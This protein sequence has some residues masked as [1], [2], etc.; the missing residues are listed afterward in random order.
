[1]IYFRFLSTLF[2]MLF[3][4]FT[5]YSFEYSNPQ[6]VTFDSSSKVMGA[7]VPT[8]FMLYSFDADIIAGWNTPL[9]KHEKKYIPEKYQKLDVLGGWYGNG[10]YP[11]K[12]VLL[13]KQIDAAFAIGT[14]NVMTKEMGKFMST[15]NI[16]FISINGNEIDD[17][18][19]IYEIL[20]QLF[21]N[22]KRSSEINE[23][24]KKSIENTKSITDK[25]KNKKKVY[26]ALGD[27]GL[28]TSCVKSILIAGGEYVHKCKQFRE[29][30]SLEQLLRY[31]PDMIIIGKK[32]AYEHIMKD[33]KWAK[34]KAVKNHNILFVPEEPF[35]WVEKKTVMEYFVIQ[36]LAAKMYPEYS[37]L[38]L[39]SELVKHL[40]IFFHYDLS[41]DMAE[42]LINY[43][44]YYKQK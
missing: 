43:E 31:N 32:A 21:H 37:S 35:S 36:Y 27:N 30:I 5:G 10:N 39:H 17:D 1:M 15:I 2:F 16:P 34:I 44:K 3:F 38:D 40:K 23:Y 12:E 9:Y 33:K 41:Y 28:N 25:V 24:I 14:S 18:I 11:N 29:T 7:T 26:L 8:T 42:K 6:N 4:A 19:K 22:E 13:S 20:G